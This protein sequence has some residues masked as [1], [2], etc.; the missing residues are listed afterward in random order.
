MQH[1]MKYFFLTFL[2]QITRGYA[3]RTHVTDTV[4]SFK[5]YIEIST[6]QS[7]WKVYLLCSCRSDSERHVTLTGLTY[8]PHVTRPR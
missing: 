5:C 6:D 8:P 7:Y 2:I 3:N 4:Y 1:G